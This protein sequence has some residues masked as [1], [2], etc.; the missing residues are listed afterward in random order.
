MGKEKKTRIAKSLWWFSLAQRAEAVRRFVGGCEL[1]GFQNPPP[2]KAATFY[3]MCILSSQK[4]V[5]K[6]G[7]ILRN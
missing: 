6:S 5:L 1:K 2:T 3:L 4:N 7:S